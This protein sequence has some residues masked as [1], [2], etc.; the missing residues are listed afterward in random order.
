MF[1]TSKL[2]I[3][4]FD[5]GAGKYKKVAPIANKGKKSGSIENEITYEG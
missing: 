5:S 4:K 1:E 3:M 2:I